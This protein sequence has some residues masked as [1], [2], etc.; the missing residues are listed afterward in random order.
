M[1]NISILFCLDLILNTV[2]TQFDIGIVLQTWFRFA[3]QF[4]DCVHDGRVA[5]VCNEMNSWKTES[6]KNVFNV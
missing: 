6:L 2:T 3:V 4:E 1:V 5:E